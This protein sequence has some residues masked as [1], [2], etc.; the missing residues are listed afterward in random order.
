MKRSFF[1]ELKQ[2]LLLL[3]TQSLELRT[4][5]N[6]VARLD[7]DCGG[8]QWAMMDKSNMIWDRSPS[9]QIQVEGDNIVRIALCK[10]E[11][12]K[13][14]EL[15]QLQRPL[16]FLQLLKN[17]VFK[18]S[19]EA[20]GRSF[21]SHLIHPEQLDQQFR[22]QQTE[23]HHLRLCQSFALQKTRVLKDGYIKQ[24]CWRYITSWTIVLAG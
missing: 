14:L 19:R 23:L 10:R 7:V 4:L 5:T 6:C 1:L 21:G 12:N 18:K 20:T 22:S 3:R 8:R 2:N 17:Q 13:W 24:F 11:E 16:L 15:L 9:P